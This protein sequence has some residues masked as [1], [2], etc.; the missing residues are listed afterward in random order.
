MKEL[1]FSITQGL[2][3]DIVPFTTH[4][5]NGDDLTT[6]KGWSSYQQQQSQ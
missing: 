3:G 2:Y 5:Q 4:T 6:F 1:I